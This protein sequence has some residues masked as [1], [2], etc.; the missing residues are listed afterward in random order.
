[1]EAR[2]ISKKSQQRPALILRNIFL[3]GGNTNLIMKAG[4]LSNHITSF[5]GV[6][7]DDYTNFLK[8]EMRGTFFNMTSR[9]LEE[10]FKKYAT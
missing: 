10:Y 8:H 1:L 3:R 4:D 5:I 9:V 2:I 7:R 6:M